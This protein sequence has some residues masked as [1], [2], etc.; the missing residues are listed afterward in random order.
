MSLTR[1]VA[2]ALPALSTADAKAHLR[3]THSSDDDLI[4]SLVATATAACEEILQRSIMPQTWL[5]VLDAFAEVMRLARPPLVSVSSVKYIDTDG[6]QQTLASSV[7]SVDSGYIT[8]RVLLAYGQSWPSIR[9]QKNAVEITYVTGYATA[10]LIPSDILGAIKLLT[11]HY[12]E[13]RENVI[14]GTML[15][16]L[17]MAAEFLLGP[18]KVPAL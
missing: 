14:A 9:D 3:V 10:A 7:Y 17:P 8:G 15:T 1:T 13:H 6:A 5:I 12:Y 4:D 11:G 18:H 16:S 2:P